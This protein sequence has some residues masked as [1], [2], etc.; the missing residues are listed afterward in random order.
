[1]RRTLWVTV[2]LLSLIMIV[3]STRRGMRRALALVLGCTATVLCAAACDGDT[4]ALA[5]L[6][7]LALPRAGEV[8][9]G[10]K[11]ASGP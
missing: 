4:F 6:G 7:L 10:T 8:M 2:W 5:S 11:L 9:D 1:M 3:V